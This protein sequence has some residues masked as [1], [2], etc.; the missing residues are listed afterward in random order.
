M[1]TDRETEELF[2]S[3]C[4]RRPKWNN[5]LSYISGNTSL[6]YMV[7]EKGK[8]EVRRSP[9]QKKKYLNHKPYNHTPL[10]GVKVEVYQWE[11]LIRGGRLLW[12]KGCHWPKCNSSKVERGMCRRHLN[13][14]RSNGEKLFTWKDAAAWRIGWVRIEYEQWET[15]VDKKIFTRAIRVWWPSHISRTAIE[16]RKPLLDRFREEKGFSLW[17]LRIM[18]ESGKEGLQLVDNLLDIE[19]ISNG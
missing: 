3:T 17:G 1:L 13:L 9:A 11:S 12:E 7:R 8:G 19:G 14:I 15:S 2:C 16:T 6:D 18:L 5:G 4:S 10:E